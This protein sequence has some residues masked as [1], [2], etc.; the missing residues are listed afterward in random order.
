MHTGQKKMTEVPKQ[1]VVTVDTEEEGLWGGNYPV[2]NCS[3]KNLRGLQRFQAT[4]DELEAPPTYLI[5]AAVLTDEQA[6]SDLKRWQNAKLCEVGAHCH[7]WCNPPI[8]SETCSS[9]ESYLCNHPAE[10]QRDKLAWLT[11]RI[12]DSLEQAPTA[13]RAGRYGFSST[14]AEILED[15]GYA[16][17]SSVIPLHDYRQDG[18]P[19]FFEQPRLPFRYFDCG[20]NL[21]ELPV[22]T[23]FTRRGLGL[24]AKLWRQ[25][26]SKPWTYIRAA[27][28]ADRL[29]IARRVKL[30][31]EGTQ[32]HDLIS[33]VDACHA[34]G[35]S[36]L[37]L[38]LH[39]S[40]LI[41]GV[42]PYAK[43]SAALDNLYSRL[44]E[45]VRYAKIQYQY[46]PA[47]LTAAAR[48]IAPNLT[49]AH[50]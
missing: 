6:A 4:C 44:V 41:P 8:V 2:R 23:G 38:M 18:G 19:D 16:V 33:L 9:V 35:L 26:R 30:S 5:D 47:L 24:R 12:A 50:T 17:D 40:S 48:A 32:L 36:T 29:G 27:G 14:S 46:Q 42:S 39:S 13:Y 28:I 34:D 11:Q 3:T 45:I 20:R 31:P 1:I 43:D 7:P 21:V 37:V 15:L 25:L 10:V 22:T 49:Q